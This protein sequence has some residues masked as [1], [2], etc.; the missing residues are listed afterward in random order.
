MCSVNCR[1]ALLSGCQHRMAIAGHSLS[2]T[3][4]TIWLS[5]AD[6]RKSYQLCS[7]VQLHSQ[8]FIDKGS[9][10]WPLGGR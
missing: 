7:R 10:L 8:L 9:C 2:S 1:D 5:S 3:S 6:V 4:Y